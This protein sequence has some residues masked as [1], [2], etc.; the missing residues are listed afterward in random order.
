MVYWYNNMIKLKINIIHY[1]DIIA[2]TY[3]GERG[4]GGGEG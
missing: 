3:T 4:G 1:S 2:G